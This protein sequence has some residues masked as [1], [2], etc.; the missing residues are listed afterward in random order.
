MAVRPFISN[1]SSFGFLEKRPPPDAPHGRGRPQRPRMHAA[2][3]PLHYHHRR[4]DP[5]ALACCRSGCYEATAGGTVEEGLL[6]LTGGLSREIAISAGA[7]AERDALWAELMGLWTTAH[8][9][10]CE[11]GPRFPPLA[12]GRAR[13][14]GAVTLPWR[15][16]S[17][18]KALFTPMHPC[19]LSV[20]WTA[21]L[22]RPPTR[23]FDRSIARWARR[24]QS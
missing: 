1:Q 4:P 9:I 5:E 13:C 15:C 14:P 8:V 12:A 19:I 6:Y 10:G 22:M 11:V 23:L 24:R 2:C 21:G 20:S 16:P 17:V 7:R 18:G 3:A